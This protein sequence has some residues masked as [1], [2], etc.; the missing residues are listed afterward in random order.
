MTPI[1]LVCAMASL[2]LGGL[3]AV[4]GRRPSGRVIVYGG[5]FGIAC[6]A[7]LASLVQLGFGISPEPRVVLPIGL[8]GLGMHFTMDDLAAA[9]L[10]ITNLG[11]AAASL[12]ALGYGRHEHEPWRILPFYPVFLAAMNLVVIA[13]DAYG[14]LLCWELMSVASWALVMAHHTDKVI[15]RA[16]TI[17][18]LMASAG[19]L[20]LLLCFGLLA[21]AHGHYAFAAMRN[22]H[23]SPWIGA[24]VMILALIGA[25]SKAGLVP[26]HVWLPHAHPAAPS[27]VSA[28]MSGVMTKVAIYAFIRI[29]FDLAGPAAWWWGLV[30]LLVGGMTAVLGVLYA[31]MEDDIKTILAYSTI[32]NVGL[33]FVGLGLAL[34]FK[35]DGMM[36]AAALALT[37]A[38]FHALNHMLFKSTLFFG[39]GAIQHAT[40]TRDLAQLG[41]LIHR[42]KISAVPMLIAAMAIAAL[43]P[44]NGFASEW[45][46]LQAILLSPALP[47]FGL[48]LAVPAVGALVALSTA[49]ASACFVRLYGIAYLG[50]A[51]TE[52]AATAHETDRFSRSAMIGL[53]GL[54]VAAGVLP[55]LVIDLL[56]PVTHAVLGAR[57]PS[58][59]GQSWLAV[60]PV[61]ASR[62]SYDPL[63]IAIFIAISGGLTALTLY[64]FGS[65]ITRHAPSW[66]CGY[67]ERDPAALHRAGQYSP[68]GFA[69]PIRRVFATLMFRAHE[70]VVV[71]P[72]GDIGPA[73]LTTHWTDPAWAAL[74]TPLVSAI[75]LI[76]DRMNRLQF[77]SIRKY[78]GF[79][80]VALVVL[81]M[82]TAL[83]R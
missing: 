9:F 8:P 77:L 53:A 23:R 28:L 4:L 81:L 43:P 27:H 68:S 2:L 22:E 20:A 16:G 83:W 78:L 49:F 59:A 12:F 69:Q 33:I 14:F 39:A 64:R 66:A 74:Y 61:T 40:G 50:R 15:R 6:A 51:R 52:R 1:I 7:L 82:W 35:A 5:S 29:V 37:A 62:S 67:Q 73:R 13:A 18:L 38:L 63:L 46:L 42:M 72:P 3:G 55:G 19:T 24:M 65:R 57:L 25:G 44:L 47:Q 70:D 56:A 71:P 48:K 75:G 45:L 26:M 30:V 80:F 10:I 36:V 11:A 54:C 76:A 41:G 60:V 17:Y 58:Q 31:L 32:E 21:G 34:A 79:V